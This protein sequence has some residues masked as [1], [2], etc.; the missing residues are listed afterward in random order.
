M[1]IHVGDSSAMNH[2]SGG[3]GGSLGNGSVVMYVAVVDVTRLRG[4][5]SSSGNGGTVVGG[6]AEGVTALG[7]VTSSST[8]PLTHN[9]THPLTQ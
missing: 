7:Q 3:Q 9:N 4:S 5:S 2:A 6:V 8:H 1:R